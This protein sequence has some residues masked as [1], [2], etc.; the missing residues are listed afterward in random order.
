VSG[1]KFYICETNTPHFIL[2]NLSVYTLSNACP[3]NSAKFF[4]D[5]LIKRV[6]IRENRHGDMILRMWSIMVFIL[7][8]FTLFY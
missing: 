3:F 8:Y 6:A 7:F 5:N 1:T 4:E 2:Q